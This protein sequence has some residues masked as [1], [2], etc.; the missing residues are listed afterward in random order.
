MTIRQFIRENREEIDEAINRVMRGQFV[1]PRLNDE[2]RR[3]WI[4]NDEGLY[5]WA[6]ASGVKI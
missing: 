3:Q 1:Q 6:K 5:W 4:L 2:E